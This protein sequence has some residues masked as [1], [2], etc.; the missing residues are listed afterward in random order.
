MSAPVIASPALSDVAS[1]SGGTTAGSLPLTNLQTDQPGLATSCRFTDLSLVPGFSSPGDI[2]TS[3]VYW[4]WDFG[5]PVNPNVIY[6][7]YASI[8]RS[9]TATVRIRAAATPDPSSSPGYDSTTVPFTSR[10]DLSL[11]GYTRFPHIAY[12]ISGFGLYRYWRADINDP[13]NTIGYIDIGRA[14]LASAISPD[15]ITPATCYTFPRGTAAGGTI[16]IDQPA[17]QLQTAGRQIYSAVRAPL[18]TQKFTVMSVSKSDLQTA[19]MGL[20]RTRGNS[21]PALWIMDPS[22]TLEIE[23]QSV[24]GLVTLSDH[25][26]SAYIAGLGNVFQVDGSIIQMR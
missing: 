7:G 6:I 13:N 22:E 17:V 10:A 8:D 12:S 4:I 24:Y 23:H 9:C 18:D 1:I 19:I 26:Y 15:G 3:G 5:V 25:P 16:G 2:S 21:R 20:R 14:F 11:H